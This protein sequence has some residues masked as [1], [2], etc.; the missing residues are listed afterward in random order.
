MREHAIPCAPFRVV[1]NQEDLR[2]AVEALGMPC[3]LK[4]A[5]F[6]YDGKGQFRIRDLSQL[7]AAWNSSDVRER[8][9][10]GWIDYEREISVLVA[11]TADGQATTWD[12]FENQHRDGILDVTIYPARIRSDIAAAAR[13][14]ALNV[15]ERMDVVG[16][17]CVELFVGRDG[18]L[19]VN[20]TAP[21]P[22]NSGHLTIEASLT[23]QFEQQAHITADL[24]LGSTALRQPAAM[25]NLLG[26]VW[27]N[28]E[29]RWERSACDAGCLV[30]SLWEN[31]TSPRPQ[32]GPHHSAWPIP[33][34][35]RRLRRS[36][37]VAA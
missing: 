20:E 33:R 27:S 11:R 1:E 26:D 9:L 3:V 4:N 14:L 5:G 18:A 37:R 19:L 25:V 7:D 10:E 2:S 24:P 15:A 21:R 34:I 16:L 36:K 29:P 30:A 13:D 32:N 12:A 31:R 17:L 8:V 35:T 22:H 23:D 28:G 6:G